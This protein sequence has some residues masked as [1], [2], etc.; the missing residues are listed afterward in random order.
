MKE[1]DFQSNTVNASSILEGLLP[2]PHRHSPYAKRREELL[3]GICDRST[4]SKE[5]FKG[6]SSGHAPS[7]DPYAASPLANHPLHAPG[8]QAAFGRET[9][10]F[11]A[12]AVPGQAVGSRQRSSDASGLKNSQRRPPPVNLPKN[13]RLS[14]EQVTFLSDVH[15]SMEVIA[16]LKTKIEALKLEKEDMH[17]E[18][19]RCRAELARAK[20]ELG[21]RDAAVALI[22][23]QATKL[24]EERNQIFKELA[25]YRSHPPEALAKSHALQ[26]ENHEL[27]AKNKKLLV[28]QHVLQEIIKEMVFEKDQTNASAGG[29]DG[30][31]G[32]LDP[33]FNLKARPDSLKNTELYHS[34]GDLG[35]SGHLPN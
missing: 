28:D 21:A 35:I 19:G 31:F 33:Y 20:E 14:S 29:P 3:G 16:Q 27:R 15:N 25:A 5:N 23:K 11:H 7:K 24:L 13:L 1:L 30:G 8:A 6:Y 9:P 10:G 2:E 34:F 17:E 32:A 12:Q 22:K 26:K 18:V 4:G